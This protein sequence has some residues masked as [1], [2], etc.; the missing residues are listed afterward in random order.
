MF[1]AL[2]CAAVV[3]TFAS[4]ALALPSA[5]EIVAHYVEA[6]GGQAAVDAIHS[7]LIRG[8]Y[9]ENGQSDD[10]AVLARMKPFYKIV[11]DPDHPSNEFAEGYDGSAW[12]FY[13]DPGIVVRTVGPAAAAARHGLYVMGDLVDY[14]AHGSR[15]A[16]LG[17]EK[18]DGRD[19]YHLRVHMLDGFEKDEFVD[20]QSWLVVAD[21]KVAKV[22]AFGADVASETRWSDYRAVN[23]VLFAFLNREVAL[24]DGHELNRFQVTAMEVN[25]AWDPVQ[26]SPP[27]LK[28]SRV[29]TLIDQLF[30]ERSDADALLWT[31]HDYKAA[32]PDENTDVA[33]E[34]AGFQILKMGDVKPAVA[35]LTANAAA[36]PSS[37]DAQFGLGR[38]LRSDGRLIEARA[39]FGRAL[40]IDPKHARALKALAEMDAKPV[41]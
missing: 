7:T 12:E 17:I 26:F 11:G 27:V 37:A 24:A 39:A 1:K 30:L 40:T 18:I 20:A 32:Y 31:L 16:V 10:H 28:R 3:L 23:G 8:V 41:R 2:A 9:T 6:I 19:A 38:A 29:Q 22:H 34:V 13:G 36:Y 33:I 4:P 25:H 35:L 15:I 14:K 21:R 5:D